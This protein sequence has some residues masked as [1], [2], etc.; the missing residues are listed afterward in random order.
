MFALRIRR[1]IKRDRKVACELHNTMESGDKR[2]ITLSIFDFL[3]IS[4]PQAHV[5]LRLCPGSSRLER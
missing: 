4:L 5:P 1:G 2:S 3:A